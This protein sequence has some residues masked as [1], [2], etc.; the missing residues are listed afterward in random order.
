MKLDTFI[1]EYKTDKSDGLIK[2]RIKKAYIPYE[3]KISSCDR[4][5]KATSY[6]KVGDDEIYSQDSTAR[7]M[8]FILELIRLYTD[9]EIDFT[10]SLECFNKVEELGLSEV[11]IN[12]IPKIEVERFETIMEMKL[13]DLHENQRSFGRYIDIQEQKNS[14]MTQ[15]LFDVI[16]E[17][18]SEKK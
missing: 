7:Y 1:K 13:D 14:I 17:I 4:I 3:E 11:I 12:H 15:N 16:D 8:L 6:K 10:H 5:I 2:S 18:V 9:I